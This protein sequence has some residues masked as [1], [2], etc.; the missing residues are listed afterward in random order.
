MAGSLT[1]IGR[2]RILQQ[3]SGLSGL[4]VLLAAC[5]RDSRGDNKI[6]APQTMQLTS[7]AFAADGLIP[8]EYTCDGA[9]H[10]PALSWD[11][12]PTGTESFTLVLVDLDASPSFIHWVLYDLP[13]DT[14]SLPA[15]IPTQPFLAA[16]VQ[17]KND[18]GQYGYRGPCSPENE[19]RYA[20]K[21]YAVNTVLDLPP[22]VTHSEV[23]SALEGQVLAEAALIGRYGRQR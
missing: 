3:F 7:P 10:S 14:R 21:L 4:G 9:D 18:F 11:D 8:I 6:Q 22:G 16:G 2:R 13:P 5:D 20:F 23:I 19:H 1:L 12:P 15:A 17:G